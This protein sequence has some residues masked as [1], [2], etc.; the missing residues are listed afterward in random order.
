[1]P[2]IVVVYVVLVGVV[3]PGSPVEVPPGEGHEVSSRDVANTA[4]S[5]QAGLNRGLD[6]PR[7][8]GGG[9]GYVYW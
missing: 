9:G 2:V 8:G 4:S 3:P 6:V 7:W 5:A 1:M